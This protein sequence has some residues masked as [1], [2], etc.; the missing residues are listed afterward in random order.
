MAG[1]KK[2]MTPE[3]RAAARIAEEAAYAQHEADDLVVINQRIE[4]IEQLVDC[5]D[6]IPASATKYVT[7]LKYKATTYGFADGRQG[8]RL[9]ELTDKQ[10]DFMNSLHKQHVPAPQPKP[11]R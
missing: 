5:I 2:L 8:S 1:F 9:L 4:M 11:N 6:S 3:E 10:V 7:D